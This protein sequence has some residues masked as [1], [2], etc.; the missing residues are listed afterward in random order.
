LDI[1]KSPLLFL[2]IVLLF[3]PVHIYSQA[4]SPDKI[5]Y[6][7]W[8]YFKDK[9]QYKPGDILKPGSEEYEVASALL[10]KKTLWRRAKVLPKDEVVNYNDLPVN[11]KYISEVRSFG[12]KLNAVSRWFNAVSVT[13]TK[14]TLNMI[15]K[16]PFVYKIEGVEY[17]DYAKTKYRKLLNKPLTDT[18]RYWGKLRYNYGLSYWQNEQINVPILH[19]C[20]ITG[21]G[22]TVGIA[23]NGF[24]WRHHQ[25]LRTRRVLGEYD[26]IFKDDSTQLQSPPNQFPADQYDQDGHGTST[27]STLGGFYNGQLIGPAFD[28][29]FYLSKT[30]D[31][32][33]ETPVEE[34]YWLEAAE[35]MEAKGVDVISCSLIYKPYDLPNNSYEYKNMDGKTT[36]IVRAADY[37]AHLGVVVVNSMGNERQ[38][39]IPSIVS[40]PDGDSVIAVGAVDSTGEIAY[41]SSN[42]PTYD[43]RIKPDVVALGVY[44]YCAVTYSDVQNDSTYTY[45]SGTSFSCPLTAGVCSL[46]LSAHPELT[47][48]QVREALRMTA[49]N[50]DNPNNI[51]GWG[52]VNAYDAVL[53]WGMAMSNKP[54]ITI[55]D[56]EVNISIYV[57]SKN[58]IDKNSVKLYY[59][60]GGNSFN[61]A[62]M[63]QAENLNETNTGKYSVT[64]PDNSEAD[65]IKIYFSAS[66]TKK[67][68]FWPY[69]APEEFFIYH[70]DSGEIEIY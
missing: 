6:R 62:N 22:T 43:G 28:V 59:S 8:I 19:Y 67:N 31:D 49:D 70:K 25:A 17:L 29:T 7:Y 66:D 56:N 61:E 60:F 47:A 18:N 10:S 23:D 15:K 50:K 20:G 39:K 27:M 52:L 26:W 2:L 33:S 35:W 40:P 21:W 42:G 12:V 16:L 34:D 41:F 64:V 5:P 37:A 36:I 11:K 63:E 38:T 32:R 55:K 4:L 24:N 30:E 3:I 58:V 1:R 13:T 68:L 65:L 54:E 14:D 44:D 57:L 48:M 51:Y 9:G 46:I 45:A 69:E 53:Y